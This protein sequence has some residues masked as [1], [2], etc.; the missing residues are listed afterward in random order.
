M[1]RITRLI[2]ISA[3]LLS[4]SQAHASVTQKVRVKGVDRTY[5]LHVP[6]GFEGALP[7]VVALHGGGSNPEGMERYSR[8]SDTA[9][10]KGFIAAY[11]AGSG[12][13]ANL[14]TWNAGNCCAYAQRTGVDDVAFIAAVIDDVVRQHGGDAT[15]VLL[16]G[17][18]NG[19]MM[20]YRF[21]ANHPEK[22]AAVAGVAGSVEF[23][24]SE[25]HGPV[26]VLHFH[27][28]DDDHVPVKGGVGPKSVVHIPFHSLDDT[29]RAWLTVN[30]ASPMPKLFPMP[31]LADDGM[32]TIRQ[33][34]QAPATH[35]PVIVYL[36]KGGGHTW[37]GSV[38]STRFLGD[39]TLDFDANE[40]M[41]EFL[42]RVTKNN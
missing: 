34:Y 9:D 25:F 17:M 16:T 11:P 35:A 3:L 7:I 27:G 21:A 10:E 24:P 6:K 33:E 8:L 19:A 15:R 39:S 40:I 12:R 38:R 23:E 5:L 28:T 36:I 2:V 20:A 29:V 4:V 30:K 18:S 22:I 42:V 37:P 14:L 26:P 31:D 41:W 32:S 13:L 1:A